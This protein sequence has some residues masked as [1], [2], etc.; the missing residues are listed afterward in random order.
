MDAEERE[1]IERSTDAGNRGDL[2]TV[3]EFLHPEVEIDDRDRSGTHRGHEGL[4]AFA[5]EWLEN[6]EEF[7]LE[8]REMEDG[9]NGVFVALTQHGKGKGS[10]IAFA[11]SPSLRAALPGRKDR[12]LGDQDDRRGR[13]ARGRAGL[14]GHRSAYSDSPAASRASSRLIQSTRRTFPSRIVHT[15][16]CVFSAGAPLTR[17]SPEVLMTETTY[18]SASISSST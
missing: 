2:E 15:P 14:K 17:P 9:P 16:A 12:L 3:L 11:P 13:T 5:Q 4:L 6:F 7:R 10:G 1:I 18:S 8:I